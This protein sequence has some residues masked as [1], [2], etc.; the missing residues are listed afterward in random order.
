MTALSAPP[1]AHRGS[2]RRRLVALLALVA[3][4]GLLWAPGRPASAADPDIGHEMGRDRL[5]TVHTTLPRP[6]F[7]RAPGDARTGVTPPAEVPRR[8]Y[9]A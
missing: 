5:R 7:V 1:V 3:A 8:I 2:N 4:L 6:S 9:L